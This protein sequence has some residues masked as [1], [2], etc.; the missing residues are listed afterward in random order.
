MRYTCS[1]AHRHFLW[2][3]LSDV[4]SP[5]ALP[6]RLILMDPNT[7]YRKLDELQAAPLLFQ[8]LLRVTSLTDRKLVREVLQSGGGTSYFQM[9]QFK[10][11]AESQLHWHSSFNLQFRFHFMGDTILQSDKWAKAKHAPKAILLV[12]HPWDSSPWPFQHKHT[13]LTFWATNHSKSH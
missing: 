12:Y 4:G 13:S 3:Y 7:S 10:R 6:H 1:H 11:H 9:L 8:D 5:F 2:R